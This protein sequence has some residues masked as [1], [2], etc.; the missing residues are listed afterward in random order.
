MTVVRDTIRSTL[1]SLLRVFTGV[2]DPV[3]FSPI[4]TDNPAG[5]DAQATALA[6]QATDYCRWA[7]FTANKG[8]QV[9]HDVLLDALT[10]KAGWVRW[11]WGKRQQIRTE[12]CEG[13]LLPQLQMLLADPGIQ[14]QRIVR[15]PMTKAEQAAVAKTAEGMMWLQQG[16]AAELWE[17][18][19]TR[20]VAAGLAAGVERCRPRAC[21]S[22]RTPPRSRRR[23][24]IFQVRDVT[25]S[26]LIEM[27]L[28]EDKVMAHADS[29]TAQQRREAMSRD[30]AQRAEHPDQPA[31]RQEPAQCALC[32]GVDHG[33]TPTATT[34]AELIHVHMLGNAENADP[35]GSDG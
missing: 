10:R 3:S 7:L 5:S 8:W 20:S 11:Y 27:G 26:E 19:I 28:P 34:V 13:L 21:G 4:S 2:D 14:A 15:R 31:E 18:R 9:L 25:A 23:K 24:A 1:P 33:P 6:R 17:A 12:V 32:R 30:W 16:G 35:V 22:W 29:M